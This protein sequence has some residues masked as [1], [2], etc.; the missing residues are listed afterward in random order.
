MNTREIIGKPRWQI[1]TGNS[2]DAHDNGLFESRERLKP[3]LAYSINPARL[4][5]TPPQFERLIA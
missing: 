4:R 5:R 1:R 3:G 2:F